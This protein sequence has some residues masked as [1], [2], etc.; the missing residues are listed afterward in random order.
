MTWISHSIFLEGIP[1]LVQTVFQFHSEATTPPFTA[2]MSVQSS[3]DM[4]TAT[5]MNGSYSQNIN[6]Q[7]VST[8]K[9]QDDL[10]QLNLEMKNLKYGNEY[11]GFHGDKLIGVS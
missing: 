1:Q 4:S 3:L 6:G 10:L 2:N 5:G 7:A 8:G 9:M 11:A